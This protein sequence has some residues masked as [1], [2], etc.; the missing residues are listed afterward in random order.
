MRAELAERRAR[1]LASGQ[2]QPCAADGLRRTRRVAVGD[3]QAPLRRFFEVLERHG[4]LGDDGR[5]AADVE[6]VSI[7]D[8]FDF[9][10]SA[11]RFD[12]ARDGLAILSW[13]ASHP[14]D[15]VR[16][17]AGNHDLG[18]VG[19]LAEFD[20]ASFSVAHERALLAYRAGDPDRE[21]ER[22]FCNAHPSFATAEFAARDLSAFS[23]AQRDLVWALLRARRLRLAHA[24]DDRLLF[25]HAG[26]T[27]DHLESINAPQ[28]GGAVAV[29]N[30]LNTALD[31]AV[32]AHVQG[33]LVV[34]SLHR[35]GHMARGEGGGMLY[36]RP[37]NPDAP[38]NRGHD[39]SDPLGRRFDPRRLPLGLT[40]V[41]GHVSDA[42]CRELLGAWA[43]GEPQPGELRQL[44]TDGARVDYRGGA[45]GAAGTPETATLIF[46]DGLMNRTPVE[47]YA[48]FEW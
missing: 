9:G 37:A 43:R 3:P 17:I 41:I 32:A 15:Q 14:P 42:K 18:R 6:F 40:Q 47:H 23:V 16:L 13:L 39:L 44:T 38:S 29:A 33:G 12:A 36:H 22:E 10:S 5:L 25:C 31:A 30:A 11:E 28:R 24:A 2:W 45:A 19:E 34:A 26:V 1:D 7:G 27:R 48:I 21:L 46:I 8:H 20:D 4:L 35:P